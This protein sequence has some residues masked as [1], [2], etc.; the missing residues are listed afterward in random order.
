M[1]GA[2]GAYA[3][4][5]PNGAVGEIAGVGQQ[6][7]RVQVPD[8]LSRAWVIV[9]TYAASGLI[10]VDETLAD[11][12]LYFL[13]VTFGSGKATATARLNLLAASAASPWWLPR[14]NLAGRVVAGCAQVPTPLPATAIAIRVGGGVRRSDPTVA[15]EVAFAYTVSVA[16]WS[17]A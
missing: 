1:W 17:L 11:Q 5:V 3:L 15:H 2:H 16:P 9:V 13:D 12:P 10:D 14:L 4:T 6:I 8:L 7:V